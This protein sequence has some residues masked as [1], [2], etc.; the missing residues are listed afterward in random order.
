MLIAQAFGVVLLGSTISFTARA[1]GAVHENVRPAFTEAIANLPGKTLT[2][3]VVSYPPG[4]RSAPH[5]HARS[6][7]I[8]AFVISGAIRSKVD[9]GPVKVYRAG[10]SWS[11]TPGAH[12]VVSEN[13]SATAPASLLA[14]FIAD[15]GDTRLTTPDK[16]TTP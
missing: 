2:S 3:V 12:H 5:T 15:T 9:D 13:A 10:D 7:Y 6:A 16:T 1:H 11:E 8:Y 14:V 4:V